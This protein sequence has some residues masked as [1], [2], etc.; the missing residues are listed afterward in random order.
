VFMLINFTDYF[1]FCEEGTFDGK[2]PIYYDP[3]MVKYHNVGQH[4]NTAVI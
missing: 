2:L 4:S 1:G 3:A